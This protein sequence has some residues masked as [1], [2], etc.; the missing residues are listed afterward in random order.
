MISKSNSTRLLL[1]P[2]LSLLLA[3]MLPPAGHGQ[4]R[5][6]KPATDLAT[7]IAEILGPGQAQLTLF[8]RSSIP[9]SELA[10]IR[11][12]LEQALRA[13][14]V[15][16]AGTESANQI[17]VTLSE[18]DHQRLWVAEIIEGSQTQYAMLPFD[19]EGTTPTQHEAGILLTRKVL[20]TSA[21]AAPS[22]ILAALETPNGLI[23]LEKEAIAIET[24][25]PTGWHEEK[26]VELSRHSIQSRD[27]RGMLIPSPDGFTAFTAN[28]Q[29]EG[30][31]VSPADWTLHCRE[32]DDPWPVNSSI[33]SPD[34]PSDRTPLRAF[35]NPARNFFTGVLTPS[36]APNLQAD[37]PPFYSIVAL[38]GPRLLLGSIDGKLQLLDG[39]NLRPVSGTRDWGS[40]FAAIRS[41][42]GSS[43]QVLAST[44][45]EAE[46]DSL[47]AYELPAQEAVP[48]SAPLEFDGTVT[49]LA[50][51]P[52]GTS[53][54]AIIRKSA[55]EWEVDRVAALC[56]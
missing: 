51:V 52:D 4:S 7:R 24:I 55:T 2:V 6:D 17:R 8:N 41:G 29:C 48:A 18:T 10:P 9:A 31:L 43:T 34:L 11:R 47:R 13:H 49:A 16:P 5:W 21:D 54:L 46:N 25:T 50:T 14:G 53:V 33:L 56:P 35:Y 32:S 42:C 27:P 22:P 26:R 30:K 12:L 1:S 45:G 28:I 15:Q 40:D 37:M 36:P 20:W 23:L 38:P 3:L 19:R 44:S 39:N